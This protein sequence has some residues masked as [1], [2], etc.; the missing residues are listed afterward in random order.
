MIRSLLVFFVKQLLQK[1]IDKPTDI[2]NFRTYLLARKY[3]FCAI[4]TNNKYLEQPHKIYQH[5]C[6]GNPTP[7][8]KT[9]LYLILSSDYIQKCH[10]Y[11]G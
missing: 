9:L 8:G 1:L 10:N 3:T 4:I 7:M 5:K 11:I 2:I 6:Y